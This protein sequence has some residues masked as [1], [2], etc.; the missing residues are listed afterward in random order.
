MR[1]DITR[2]RIVERDGC[3]HAE[4]GT[5]ARDGDIVEIDVVGGTL[6]EVDAVSRDV[7][8]T[9]KRFIFGNRHASESVTQRQVRQDVLMKRI[10]A[11]INHAL[12]SRRVFR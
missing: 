8:T 12:R 2:V 11:S 6:M 10:T 4:D 1:L 9:A 5:E 7:T 3:H